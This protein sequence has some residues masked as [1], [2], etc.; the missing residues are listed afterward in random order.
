MEKQKRDAWTLVSVGAFV[1]YLVFMLYP[2]ITLLAKSVVGP[3]GISF[4]AFEK[5]F[6]SKYYYGVILNSLAVTVCVTFLT[7]IIAVPL[8]YILTTVK[9]RFAS[10]IQILILISSTSAPFIGAYSWILLLGRNGVVTNL[11]KSL[12]GIQLPGI[13]GFPGILLVLTLQPTPLIYMYVAGALKTVDRSLIEAAESMRC[14]GIQ[15]MLKIIAPLILPTILAGSLLVFMRALADFGTPMLIGEGFRTVPVLIFN[16]FISEMGEDDSFA[17]AISVMVVIFA[18]SIFLVQKFIAEKKAYKMSSLS[19]IQAKKEKGLRSIFAHG[20]VY[21]Y[22]FLAIMPQLYVIYTSFLKTSGKIFVKG[23]SLDSYVVAF[24]KVGDAIRNSFVLGLIALVVIIIVASLI[25]YVTVRRRSS[26]TNMLDVSTMFPYIVPGSI[27]GIALIV[28]FN[29]QPLMLSGT[30]FIMIL[31]FTIR[32]LPYTIRSSSAILHQV[33]IS[34]EE[35][36]IS[37]GASKFKTFTRVTLPAMLPGIFSGAILS[38]ISILTELS[39]SILLYTTATRTMT[40]A[41]YTE[42][43][44]GNYGTAA[45]LSAI[46]SAVTVISLLLFFKLSGKRELSM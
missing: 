2:L 42:V 16:E 37:L 32:R 11:C 44:R 40:I 29:K 33:N 39:T 27:L 1:L 24:S 14:T 7:I 22:I 46:L 18:I 6:S 38:W 25:A 41:I 4:A 31:A 21:L 15:K 8:A 12:F 13:Y 34:T 19:P 36:A 3:E 26:L 10:A 28:T 20:F 30:A 17:A 35:A 43:L 45:A 23:Y 9:I 5:F